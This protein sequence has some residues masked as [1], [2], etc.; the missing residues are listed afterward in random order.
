MKQLLIIAVLLA[1]I[2]AGAW[3]VT[4]EQGSAAPGSGGPRRVAQVVTVVAEPVRRQTLAERVEALGTTRASESVTLTANLTD[5]VRRINFSD[6]DYVEAGAVLVELTN[7][8]EQ[9]QLAEAQAGLAEA[10][11]QLARLADLGQRGIAPASDVD[12]ARAAAEGAQARLNT[13]LARLRDRVIR[14][15]FSGLLGFR[16]VSTGTLV[17]PGTPITTLDDISQI[18]LDFTIPETALGLVAV[19]GT[20]YARSAAWGDREFT[21][22]IATVGSRVDPVTRAATVRAIIPNGDRLLR[23]GMLLTVRVVGRER[24]ALVVAEKAIIQMG[25]DS[26]VFTIDGE[27]KARRTQVTLGLRQFGI[28]EVLAGLRE[29]D[30][31]ITEGIIKI[32][33]GAQVSIEHPGNGTVAPMA[34]EGT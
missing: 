15:P 28:V 27:S 31:V 29:G 4:R 18:K 8:E 25:A 10:Q 21:G 19:G 22:T 5:T 9:A 20:V 3:Y 26:F 33:D 17:T 16:E 2:A 32:R 12:E 30:V 23:P 11:R 14:A 7:E 24:Q 1:A 13:I 6:G 34:T